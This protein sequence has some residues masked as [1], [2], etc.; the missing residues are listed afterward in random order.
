MYYLKKLLQSYYL[1]YDDIIA[2]HVARVLRK[3][4]PVHVR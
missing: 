2:W 3:L 1:N 4:R